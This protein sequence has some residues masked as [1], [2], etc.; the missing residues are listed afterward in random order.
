MPPLPPWWEGWA[1]IEKLLYHNFSINAPPLP[2]IGG[3][4]INREIIIL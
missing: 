4:G 1:L 3:A 2:P